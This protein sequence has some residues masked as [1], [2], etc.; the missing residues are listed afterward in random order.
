M[1]KTQILLTA[2]AGSCVVALL[3]A[4]IYFGNPV[5]EDYAD[6]F[7]GVDA[8]YDAPEEIKMRVDAMAAFTN[9]FVIGSTGIT[10]NETKL[11]D[12]CQYIYDKGLKF[13]V[14]T[15]DHEPPTLP[16]RQWIENA[17]I[18]WSSRFLGLYVYDE[19]GGKQLDLYE[20]RIV[21]KADNNSDA[22]NQFV[23]HIDSLIQVATSNTTANEG[24]QV[25]SSD[26][27]LYWFDYKA[28]YDVLFAEFGW[29]YSRQMNVAFCR[30]AA[31]A[32]KKEWGVMITW[33]YSVE[34]YL[35]SGE[36]LFKDMVS[37]YDNG[38]K[39]IL[40]FDTNENYTNG[41][42]MEEH[43]QAI[44]QFTQY[45]HANPRKFGRVSERTVFVLP[46][47]Y[48][49]GFRGPEDKIWG[50]W[51]NDAFSYELSVKLGVFLEEYGNKLDVIYDDDVD[52]DR[53]GYDKVI[54]WN[55]TTLK[56]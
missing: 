45:A 3:F 48:G 28:G 17:K 46:K 24:I 40:I 13:I 44:K 16:S 1:K 42:L 47:D 51:E 55:G 25:F 7:V 30:G 33:T 21:E 41:V 23:A 15:D 50:L 56:R 8:A 53:L 29:N 39:Y 6:V 43:V 12:L 37:A 4:G 22:R 32:Q 34:P 26:Y 11:T 5:K 38:A 10:F 19:V 36:E 35:E 14:Y 18:R 20:W 49:Y 31:E 27:A 54:F 2:I 52:Y 9:V